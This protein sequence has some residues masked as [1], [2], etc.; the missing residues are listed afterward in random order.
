MPIPFD[1][2]CAGGLPT[3]LV[4]NADAD[5]LY[6]ALEGTLPPGRVMTARPKP[7][8]VIYV[9]PE[10]II[11]VMDIEPDLSRLKQQQVPSGAFTNKDD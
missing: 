10:S 6:R 8:R 11:S 9:R 7:G 5:R 2:A 4:S 3:A 1:A